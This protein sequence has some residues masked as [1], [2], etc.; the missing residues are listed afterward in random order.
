MKKGVDRRAEGEEVHDL[1]PVGATSRAAFASRR[2]RRK[3]RSRDTGMSMSS[4]YLRLLLD[5][6]EAVVAY[7]HELA[8]LQGKAW[9]VRTCHD[10]RRCVARLPYRV[11]F[12]RFVSCCLFR[13]PLASTL[14]TR[15]V[16]HRG[17]ENDGALLRGSTV[18][19]AFPSS[20]WMC[21]QGWCG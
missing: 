10:V 12:G 19:F 9:A 4:R 5:L 15:D 20:W 13:C 1:A 6:L 16:L 11:V 14:L 2:G 8:F 7:R 17:G 21:C 3:R 18:L